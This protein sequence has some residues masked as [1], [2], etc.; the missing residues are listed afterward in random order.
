PADTLTSRPINLLTVG[1]QTLQ[2]TDSVALTFYYEARG[3]GDS[4]ELSD[5]L[6]VDFYKPL[7]PVIVNPTLTTYGAWQNNVWAMRGNSNPN[8][9]DT[10]F[11]RGFIWI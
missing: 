9:N 3:F 8:I 2:A 10:V 7:A 4:P 6:L 11:K 1:A 5:T